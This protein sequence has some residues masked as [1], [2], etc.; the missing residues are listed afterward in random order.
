MTPSPYTVESSV[1]LKLF[2]GSKL[3]N[4]PKLFFPV[5]NW[6]STEGNYFNCLLIP[7]M[8]ISLKLRSNFA[9]F[10]QIFD[11]FSGEDV[12]QQKMNNCYRHLWLN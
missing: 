4:F 2:K 1:Y 3:W 12:E 11:C 5:G 10:A 9:P 8:S 7:H 6:W